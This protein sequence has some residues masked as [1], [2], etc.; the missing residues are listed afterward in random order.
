MLH[1]DGLEYHP[2]R[3]QP[4][5]IWFDGQTEYFAFTK[6]QAE[7]YLIR[8]IAK[9]LDRLDLLTPMMRAMVMEGR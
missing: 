9:R 5:T 8:R 1:P 2:G 4:W 3:Q 6:T 7:R